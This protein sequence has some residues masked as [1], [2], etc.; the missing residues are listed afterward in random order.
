M[1]DVTS[2]AIEVSHAFD[3]RFLT[4]AGFTVL[5]YDIILTIAQEVRCVW[6]RKRKLFLSIAFLINRYGVLALAVLYQFQVLFPTHANLCLFY[7]GAVIVL[8][9]ITSSFG[10][11]LALYALFRVWNSD[12]KLSWRMA[13][14]FI[15]MHALTTAFG[16]WAIRQL[17]EANGVLLFAPPG[18]N[19]KTC[20]IVVNPSGLLGVYIPAVMLDVYSFTLLL[21]NALAR[22]RS[23]SQFLTDILYRDGIMFFL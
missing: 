1:A 20:A 5:S 4:L 9:I 10:N 7:V 14:G 17:Q 19:L 3:T 23:A 18:V 2:L 16:L 15:A 11:G 21:L 12:K 6:T 8:D 13:S 22:P